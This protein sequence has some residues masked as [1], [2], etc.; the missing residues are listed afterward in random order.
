MAILG[1][2]VKVDLSRGTD[3]DRVAV[4]HQIGE[5]PRMGDGFTAVPVGVLVDQWGVADEFL[6]DLG[7]EPGEVLLGE[8]LVEAGREEEALLRV[9]LRFALKVSG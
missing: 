3:A 9:L 2:I 7:D 6:D 5:H 8:P 4:D 1:V